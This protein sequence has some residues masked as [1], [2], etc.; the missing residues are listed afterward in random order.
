VGIFWGQALYL[1]GAR[2]HYD[3][4]NEGYQMQSSDLAK[5]YTTQISLTEWLQKINY[6]QTEELRSADNE[7]R[8]RLKVLNEVIGLPFDQPHQF[9]A[10]DVADRTAAF[11][12]FLAE[13][14]GELCAI[15]LIPTSPEL[16]KLRI[17]GHSIADAVQWF[18]EQ[19]ID[20]DKY[21]VD[22]VP[23][24][25]SNTWSTIFIVNDKGVFGEIIPGGHSQLTQGFYT[26]AEPIVFTFDF[27]NW[28]LSREDKIALAELKAI[29][30]MLKVAKAKDRK[31]LTD[32]L[33]ATFAGN[34]L[35]GYF[36]TA[37]SEDYGTWF[38][39][40]N[41]MLGEMYDN[42]SVSLAKQ[43]NQGRNR[44]SGMVASQG[45]VTGTAHILKADDD[46]NTVD[47][48]D[49]SVLVCAMTT[50][51]HLPLMQK[52]SGIVTDIGGILSHAAI[53]ARE[54]GIPCITGTK[55]ATTTFEHG[56]TLHVDA[57]TG[58]VARA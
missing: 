44:L 56:E 23:H 57:D 27:K 34:Y 32:R 9:S 1:A 52:A 37:A 19:K 3:Q 51:D 5:L 14:R 26:S 18:D 39:D 6:G 45:K 28:Q 46:L 21:R 25:E 16:A 11:Q 4:L 43:P 12:D 53:V 17:R 47:F 7:K 38:I 55:T 29:I 31:T 8:E 49:G 2:Y 58:V 50:P 13:H 24:T 20:V 48:K 15:R 10:R 33:D 42:F 30:R 35:K 40:Y 54:L 22:F 41:R 36:E